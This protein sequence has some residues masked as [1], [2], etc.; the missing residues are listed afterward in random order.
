MWNWGGTNSHFGPSLVA[1]PATFGL[2]LA[3]GNTVTLET[4]SGS[5]VLQSLSRVERLKGHQ[6]GMSARELLEHLGFSLVACTYRGH[7]LF[8]LSLACPQ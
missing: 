5:L 4:A 7:E 1:G 6:T 3:Q 8:G 2:K